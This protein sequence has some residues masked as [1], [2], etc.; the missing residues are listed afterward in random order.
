M[1]RL[2]QGSAGGHARNGLCGDAG[3]GEFLFV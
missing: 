2:I 1:P 3:G